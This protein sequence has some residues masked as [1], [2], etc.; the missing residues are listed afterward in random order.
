MPGMNTLSVEG[1]FPRH[2]FSARFAETPGQHR[3]TEIH[4][5]LVGIFKA[6][7]FQRRRAFKDPHILLD[8][9]SRLHYRPKLPIYFRPCDI[10]R[11]EPDDAISVNRAERFLI[12]SDVGQTVVQQP[13]V[14]LPVQELPF[15]LLQESFLLRCKFFVHSIPPICSALFERKKGAGHWFVKTNNPAP[16]TL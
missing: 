13:C 1:P 7:S 12:P 3:I 11:S 4:K 8:L 6:N 16:I 14:Q 5:Y 10:C 9:S 15:Y 2:K